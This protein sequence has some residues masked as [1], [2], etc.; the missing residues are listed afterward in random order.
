M[1]GVRLS[2]CILGL[3]HRVCHYAFLVGLEEQLKWTGKA[4][5]ATISISWAAAESERG[6]TPHSNISRSRDRKSTKYQ[7]CAYQLQE[8]ES[9]HKTG[10]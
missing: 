1:P 3:V 5:A 10:M 8:Q 7:S 9:N 6:V 2:V 4:I